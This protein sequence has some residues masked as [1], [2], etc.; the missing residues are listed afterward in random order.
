MAKYRAEV[1]KLQNNIFVLHVLYINFIMPINFLCEFD[2]I[3][4]IFNT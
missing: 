2:S 4:K 1:P 3:T